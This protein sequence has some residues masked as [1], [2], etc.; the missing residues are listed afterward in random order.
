MRREEDARL[1]SYCQ[2]TIP[3]HNLHSSLMFLM[4][5]SYI[6]LPVE[7]Y[8]GFFNI[9]DL[10]KSSRAPSGTQGFSWCSSYILQFRQH[11]KETDT[12]KTKK[13]T[14]HASDVS[15]SFE[16]SWSL[17]KTALATKKT[18]CSGDT[19]S[20]EDP[21]RTLHWNFVLLIISCLLSST[22]SSWECSKSCSLL[23]H[24]LSTMKEITMLQFHYCHAHF[25][26]LKD[27][28]TRQN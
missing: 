19:S 4:N 21:R 28:M 2:S 27:L 17:S 15:L 24:L 10:S 1:G 26:S 23:L 12:T 13:T 8:W 20:Y 9:G 18:S 3:E 25:A 7:E 5:S 6:V 16:E 14:K 11:G 22:C